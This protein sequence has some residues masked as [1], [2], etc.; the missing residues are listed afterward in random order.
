[1]ANAPTW[2]LLFRRLVLS[3]GCCPGPDR[4]ATSLAARTPLPWSWCWCWPS[5]LARAEP[6]GRDGR[7]L[8]TGPSPGCTWLWPLKGSVPCETV[9]RAAALGLW[10]TPSSLLLG[11][12]RVARAF[13]WR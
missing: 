4:L 8:W 6:V 5:R 11:A 2:M 12:W 1:M 7:E 3:A 13:G 10:P 9:D